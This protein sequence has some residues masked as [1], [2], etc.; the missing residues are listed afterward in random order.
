MLIQFKHHN[1]E[2]KKWIFLSDINL[3]G[4][5]QNDEHFTDNKLPVQYL[6]LER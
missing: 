4:L 3:N 1:Q 6:E 5:M 2:A